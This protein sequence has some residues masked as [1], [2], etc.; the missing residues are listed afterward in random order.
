MAASIKRQ[1]KDLISSTFLKLSLR[2][3]GDVQR[4]QLVNLLA[5]DN[6]VVDSLQRLLNSVCESCPPDILKTFKDPMMG[7]V[8]HAITDFASAGSTGQSAIQNFLTSMFQ[9]QAYKQL[10]ASGKHNE[11]A[12]RSR[13]QMNP[14]P[15]EFKE[16]KPVRGGESYIGQ[17]TPSDTGIRH[18]TEKAGDALIPSNLS[19]D[20]GKGYTD[21]KANPD[22]FMEG[23]SLP[24]VVSIREAMSDISSSKPTKDM[25][26]ESSI[27]THDTKVDQKAM[28]DHKTQATDGLKTS[29]ENK[30]GK[31]ETKKKHPNTKKNTYV[32][33]EDPM[34]STYSTPAEKK[35]S[36]DE[37]MIEAADSEQNVNTNQVTPEGMQS[38]N[39][40]VLNLLAGLKAFG[41]TPDI[42][43][44]GGDG[45]TTRIQ[46]MRP[47]H[48]RQQAFTTYTGQPQDTAPS[49]SGSVV[50]AGVQAGVEAL[51]GAAADLL[52]PR[53][54]A[55]ARIFM[56]QAFREAA[57]FG[58]EK[59]KEYVLRQLGGEV[60]EAEIPEIEKQIKAH[61][62]PATNRTYDPQSEDGFWSRHMPG[63]AGISGDRSINYNLR[64]RHG[65]MN[66]A[67][68]NRAD[69]FSFPKSFTKQSAPELFHDLQVEFRK[70]FVAAFGEETAKKMETEEYIKEAGGIP[71][72]QLGYLGD[73]KEEDRARLRNII[74]TLT[75][76]N[77]HTNKEN[78]EILDDAIVTHGANPLYTPESRYWNKSG[79]PGPD[80]LATEH[81]AIAWEESHDKRSWVQKWWEGDPYV[82]R[83]KPG[84]LRP[85]QPLLAPPPPSQPSTEASTTPVPVTTATPNT[86]TPPPPPPAQP[87]SWDNQPQAHEVISDTTP[88][89]RDRQQQQQQQPTLQPATAP[90]VPGRF[91]KG[92][93]KQW[94][95]AWDKGKSLNNFRYGLALGKD[96]SFF[97]QLPLDQ[98]GYYINESA[99]WYMK[100]VY[101]KDPN[102][103]PDEY[104]FLNAPYSQTGASDSKL[105]SKQ[106]NILRT[107]A[108][109][110]YNDPKDLDDIWAEAVRGSQDYN[111]KGK[112]FNNR[113]YAS[114]FYWTKSQKRANYNIR[115]ETFVE[116]E[117]SGVV[118]RRLLGV[119][120]P[121]TETPSTAPAD[122]ATSSAAP[123][124]PAAPT[125]TTSQVAGSYIR[126]GE[127]NPDYIDSI[128]GKEVPPPRTGY[129]QGYG[130]GSF[131][132]DIGNSGD[133]QRTDLQSFDFPTL[134]SFFQEGNA[135]VVNK[136]NES[137]DAKETNRATWTSFNDE[138]NWEGCMEPDNDLH[139]M[140]VVEEGRRFYG[141]LD[142][143]DIFESQCE[144][145]TQETYDREQKTVFRLPERCRLDGES[146][147]L[148][149]RGGGNLVPLSA[150]ETDVMFHDVYM[151]TW[152]EIPESSGYKQFTAVEGTQLPDSMLEDPDCFASSDAPSLNNINRFIFTTDS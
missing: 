102:L 72:W 57:V 122:T 108:Q 61:M 39:P 30:T 47:G 117:H 32:A 10:R 53:A 106:Y 9:S 77:Y 140:G 5:H 85:E 103:W 114:P 38:L 55:L 8:W 58:Y 152:A 51:S 29:T 146:L 75:H 145:A 27:Q 45:S 37:A 73:D 52:F 136:V 110:N 82:Y 68:G 67:Y 89:F 13:F 112:Y 80:Y 44:T 24:K 109:G 149:T 120:P 64:L 70:R 125:D 97:E 42:M 128:R 118:G 59:L 95:Q 28:K 130:E 86:T 71:L 91:K 126:S 94:Q 22:A 66:G 11:M 18:Q 78:L 41:A 60:K 138:L 1:L 124:A 76:G 151:P 90:S 40:S 63:I 119:S 34:T 137:Q 2:K 50:Q 134:R 35:H 129:T 127:Q 7:H 16:N 79:G 83:G 133:R 15:K 31:T 93:G 88:T 142:M 4:G 54:S 99:K 62:K 21:G 87:D 98:L 144:Q 43:N 135:N 113:G 74:K 92:Q 56:Q 33:S 96:Y 107:L 26:Y 143:D 23:Q 49:T 36:R 101:G 19:H 121:E 48:E 3:D 25:D 104:Q 139:M 148:D 12:L 65:G 105:Q 17:P 115:G 141:E 81:Q 20:Q 132:P 14:R 100:S 116:G 46:N 69:G 147:I 84:T 150:D 111:Y 6:Q 131:T 123:E